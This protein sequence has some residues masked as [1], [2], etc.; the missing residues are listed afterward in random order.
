MIK[1]ML[2]LV[3]AVEN[4]E[5][6]VPSFVKQYDNMET[7]AMDA[8][9]INLDETDPLVAVCMPYEEPTGI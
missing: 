2:V 4:G 7:C 6:W 3:M 5:V 8:I 1:F 9:T